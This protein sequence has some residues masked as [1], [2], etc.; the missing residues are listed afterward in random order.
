MIDIWLDEVYTA[1]KLQACSSKWLNI[2]HLFRNYLR[3]VLKCITLY[4]VDN[5]SH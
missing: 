4:K 1:L 3:A 5:K 2:R